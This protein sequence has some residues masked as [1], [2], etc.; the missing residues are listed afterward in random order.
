MTYLEEFLAKKKLNVSL[1]GPFA[2]AKNK[3]GRWVFG[4][5]LTHLNRTPS[6]IGDSLSDDDVRFLIVQDPHERGL[7][8][9]VV[10]DHCYAFTTGNSKAQITEKC[11]VSEGF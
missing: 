2:R 8:G 9:A 7:P 3:H 6:P 4:S 5:Y 11:L 1:G 10:T